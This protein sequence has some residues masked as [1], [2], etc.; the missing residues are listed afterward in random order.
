MGRPSSI[1]PPHW[2]FKR[3]K[4]TVG[5][6]QSRR[7]NEITIRSRKDTTSR[8]VKPG[9]TVGAVKR[10]YPGASCIER[11]YGGAIRLCSVTSPRGVHTDFVIHGRVTRVDIYVPR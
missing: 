4:L 10:A 2:S 5:F 3:R 6:D 7:V 1:T 9:A 8:G 11:K